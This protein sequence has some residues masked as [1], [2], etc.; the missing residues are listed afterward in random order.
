MELAAGRCT[1]ILERPADQRLRAGGRRD[2][3]LRA[4]R[5]SPG[6][7][8]FESGDRRPFGGNRLGA[9]CCLVLAGSDLGR[10]GKRPFSV[11]HPVEDG[12]DAE[13]VF[14][15]HRVELVGMAAGTVERQAE[16]GLAD[17]ADHV[18]HLLLARDGTL[19]GVGLSIASPI[20]GAA[21][22]HARG[23]DAVAGH[24]LENIAGELFLHEAVVGLVVVEALDDVIAVV[25]G[26]VAWVVVFEPFALGVADDVEPVPPPAFAVVRRGEEVID[27]AL[28]GS[29]RRIGHEGL[30]LLGA[31]RKADQIEEQPPD[32]GPRISGGRRAKAGS[33]KPFEHPGIDRPPRPR[34]ERC[35]RERRFLNRLER[36]PIPPGPLLRAEGER[37][38]WLLPPGA[39]GVDPGAEECFFFR[40]ERVLGG[41]L[42]PF[43]PLPEE[44]LRLSRLEGRTALSPLG[45][46]GGIDERQP[47][48]RTGARV[49]FK[50]A[51]REEGGDLPVEVDGGE[52]RLRRRSAGPR[53]DRSDG[54]DQDQRERAKA[55]GGVPRGVR[56]TAPLISRARSRLCSPSPDR[57]RA[58]GPKASRWPRGAAASG[59]PP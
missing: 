14:L 31:R 36:P 24:R 10:G 39:P 37:I 11:L 21:D 54:R 2:A 46:G 22:E 55:H 9:G 29:I 26:A 35:L 47:A 19:R 49:A 7:F 15:G 16:E 25:P 5:S 41:H 38:E 42:V 28:V 23:D 17:D 4:F 13:V 59:T 50:A 18:L 56:S 53:R 40:W 3:I 52:T 33:P 34:I 1:A 32:E 43:D 48:I 44:A 57:H 51:R 12:L 27:N 58:A 30:D 20:P 6:P 8:P 45:R